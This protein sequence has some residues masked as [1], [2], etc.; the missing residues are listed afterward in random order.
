MDNRQVLAELKKYQP[1]PPGEE[2]LKKCV[3]GLP[4]MKG[5]QS[6]W[7]LLRLQ[8]SYLPV[9]IYPV[10]AGIYLCV[11]LGISLFLTDNFWGNPELSQTAAIGLT[12]AL[13]SI[14]AI[15]LVQ[16][17]MSDENGMKELELCCRYHYGQI[18]LARIIWVVGIAV[19]FD[20]AVVLLLFPKLGN[21]VG[22]INCRMIIPVLFGAAVTLGVSIGWKIKSNIGIVIIYVAGSLCAEQLLSYAISHIKNNSAVFAVPIVA[23]LIV[24]CLQGKYLIK[25]S[26][27]YEAYG[28]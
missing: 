1:E 2:L 11:V 16:F 17:F 27:T 3:Q 9:W 24:L 6:M 5:R 12:L 18:M 22:Y 8:F 20:I 23:L 19:L 21:A 7:P 28:M 10:L 25:R 14:S 13:N 15:L 26:W 4:E